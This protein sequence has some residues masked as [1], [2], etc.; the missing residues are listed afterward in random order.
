MKR[1]LNNVNI[2]PTCGMCALIFL[3]VCSVRAS[4]AALIVWYIQHSVG[5]DFISHHFAE[6]LIN[7]KQL[8]VNS[9]MIVHYK[10]KKIVFINYVH[11]T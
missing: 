5:F 1:A 8:R 9:I 2:K 11:F 7:N 3:F 6:V 10:R 4:R